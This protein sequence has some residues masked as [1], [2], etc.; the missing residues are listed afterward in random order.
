MNLLIFCTVQ[1]EC[2]RYK[3]DNI[4]QVLQSIAEWKSLKTLK[5]QT[6]LKFLGWKLALRKYADKKDL[7]EQLALLS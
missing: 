4:F 7:I 2:P 6:V 1:T 3:T 5:R